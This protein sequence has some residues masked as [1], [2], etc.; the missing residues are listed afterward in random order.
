[1]NPDTP[2]NAYANK[3]IVVMGL[4]RFGGGV[5]VTRW[6]V[7]SGASV[8]I[9]DPADAE[10]L[11]A[12]LGQLADLIA[13]NQ[14]EIV[15]APHDPSMLDDTD[16][17]VVN[18][19]VPVPWNNPFIQEAQSRSIT[20]TTEI[21]IAYRQ[22]NPDRIIAITG[23]AGKSTTSAM[24]HHILESTGCDAILAGN[25]GG[26]LLGRLD[27]I[28]ADTVIVLELS[29]AMI[30]WLWGCDRAD[31]P[32]PYPKAA[33]ITN[34]APN[35][36]DWHGD[37]TH[38][39]ESKQRLI[40]ILGDDSTAILGESIANWAT[41][42]RAEVRVIDDEISQC[43]I[44]GKH[45]ATNAAMAVGGA[46]AIAASAD[47]VA[48]VEAVRGFAGLPHRLNR[49]HEGGGIVFF[50][51]SKSTTPAATLLAV[52]AVGEQIPREHIH[53][54]AGGADKGSDLSPIANLAASLAGLSTIGT[55]GPSL[56]QHANASYC[57]T[58]DAAMARAINAAKPGDAIVL[59][60][61]CAS[62]DQFANYE[63]RGERF[64]EL[65]KALTSARSDRHQSPP[66]NRS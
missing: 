1:M 40:S 13:N 44:P 65:A 14:L 54:I 37:E 60:P 64:V 58:L 52:D 32:M 27:Q 23:S 62:W 50:N 10:S 56:A 16:I 9:T 66:A 31:E 35:H 6:L 28:N 57:E 49:C 24:I 15:H 26:S 19:A 7:E 46:L 59:S 20:I 33:C 30:Y 51:D 36:L 61:G 18:P 8:L 53:L 39:L 47:R 12:S 41:H 55:T 17:L 34:Y 4:G 29:S 21:E 3:R 42:T 5:G 25:I 22:L 2:S 45:N 43:A 38:Y 63:H 11:S 48:M